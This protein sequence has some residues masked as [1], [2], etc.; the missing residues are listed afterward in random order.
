[1]TGLRA[2]GSS[3][4]SDTY[5]RQCVGRELVRSVMMHASC[6]GSTVKN[7]G[8]VKCVQNYPQIVERT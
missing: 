7:D 8:A 1:M 2:I 6:D 5:Y 3:R 4:I